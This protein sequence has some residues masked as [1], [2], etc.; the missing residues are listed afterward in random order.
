MA[1]A[2]VGG[3]T[4]RRWAS[5]AMMPRIRLATLGGHPRKKL[6]NSN[7]AASASNGG[8]ATGEAA[9]AAAWATGGGNG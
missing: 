2:A 5:V 4:K 9:E 3:R 7:L 6:T 1:S 8:R